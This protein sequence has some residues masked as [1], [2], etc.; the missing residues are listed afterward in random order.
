MHYFYPDSFPS[1]LENRIPSNMHVHIEEKRDRG[2][3]W[4]PPK[5]SSLSG[6]SLI[7]CDLKKMT[8]PI[9]VCIDGSISSGKSTILKGLASNY[10]STHPEPLDEWSDQLDKF[11]ENPLIEFLN[12]QVMVL[13]SQMRLKIDIQAQITSV[14]GSGLLGSPVN[15]AL[16]WTE[17]YSDDLSPYKN[18][19][20]SFCGG[21]PGHPAEGTYGERNEG[22]DGYGSWEIQY[23]DAGLW[24]M[25]TSERVQTDLRRNNFIFIERNNLSQLYFIYAGLDLGN[26]SREDAKT[27]L[28]LW[29]NQA[30]LPDI[31]VHMDTSPSTCFERIQNRNQVGDSGV[32]LEYLELLNEHYQAIYSQMKSNP[33]YRC[34]SLPETDTPEQSLRRLFSE[35]K[36]MTS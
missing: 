17:V 27:F 3:A 29:R 36:R 4:Q 19:E 14:Y 1:S 18:F 8:R 16:I 32:S 30:W 26:I 25:P 34:I 35:L 12:T 7:P 20:P 22:V 21:D 13:R 9:I 10:F 15:P 28:G 5:I 11:Y 6:G 31:M 23:L 24:D 33:H 2:D